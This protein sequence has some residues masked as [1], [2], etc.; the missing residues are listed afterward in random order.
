M[1]AITEEQIKHYW[2]TVIPVLKAKSERKPAPQA[3]FDNESV[4]NSMFIASGHKFSF[5]MSPETMATLVQVFTKDNRFV[6]SGFSFLHAGDIYKVAVGR[7]LAL[8]DALRAMSLTREERREVW[9][10]YFEATKG[11]TK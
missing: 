4:K 2:G 10:K 11:E 8:T 5:S 1:I 7:K 3:Y 6:T 9:N